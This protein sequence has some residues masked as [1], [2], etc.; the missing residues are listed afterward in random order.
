MVSRKQWSIWNPGEITGMVQTCL[1]V[2]KDGYPQGVKHLHH[3]ADRWG[4]GRETT[5]CRCSVVSITIAKLLAWT[6][7]G[8]LIFFRYVDDLAGVGETNY[9]GQERTGVW[10]KRQ[11]KKVVKL[12]QIKILDKT[13]DKAVAVPSDKLNK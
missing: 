4:R 1:W 6:E 12:S 7:I 11:E 2:T 10:K 9:I 3:L 8:W 5:V 13:D